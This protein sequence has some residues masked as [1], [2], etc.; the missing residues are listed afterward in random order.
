MYME[1]D[2]CIPLS[3]PLFLTSLMFQIDENKD[4]LTNPYNSYTHL[5][6]KMPDDFQILYG[7]SHLPHLSY[8]FT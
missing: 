8:S 3:L 6:G 4:N 1:Q 7:T 5:K 2:S